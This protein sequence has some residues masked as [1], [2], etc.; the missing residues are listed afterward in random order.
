MSKTET[1]YLIPSL[2]SISIR[3]TAFMVIK[4]FVVS[5]SIYF[6]I[7]AAGVVVLL[8]AAIFIDILVVLHRGSTLES[9]L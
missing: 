8:T 3:K 6:D 5:S 2:L 7:A 1:V 4:S 9:A